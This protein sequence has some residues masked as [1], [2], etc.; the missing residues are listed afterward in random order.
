MWGANRKKSKPIK[1]WCEVKYWNEAVRVHRS[2]ESHN[3]QFSLDELILLG[4]FDMNNWII[5]PLMRTAG[6]IGITTVAKSITFSFTSI[7]RAVF[8]SFAYLFCWATTGVIQSV[9]N[10]YVRLF[11]IVLAISYRVR[12]WDK[13]TFCFQWSNGCVR[14]RARREHTFM[15]NFQIVF[16]RIHYLSHMLHLIFKQQQ[17]K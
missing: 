12:G 2:L 7:Y 13:H 10:L 11:N 9:Y 16:A 1:N 14:K 15:N 6:V 3:F 4:T 8:S 17:Q 5:R